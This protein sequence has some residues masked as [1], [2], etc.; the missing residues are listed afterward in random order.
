MATSTATRTRRRSGTGRRGPTRSPELDATRALALVAAAVVLVGAGPLPAWLAPR[1][2]ALTIGGALP[3]VFAV[4]AGV[5]IAHQQAA[6]AAAGFRWWTGRILRRVV[7][8]VAA[9]V[10]L[11]LLLALPTPALA[12]LSVTGDLA[13]LGVATGLGLVLVHVPARARDLLAAALLAAHGWL[14]VGA[15]A[16]TSAGGA[17]AGWDARLLA[18][19]A[20]SPVDPDG[21]TAVAPT[22]A[23]VL[24]GIA[25]GEW[26]RARPRGAPTV[27][28][29]AA[30][31]V[32]TGAAAAGLARVLPVL[33]AV[34]TAPV[35]AAGVALALA[36]LALGQLGTR[37]PWSDRWVATLAVAGRTTLPLW[38]LA[39]LAVRWF[40]GTPPVRWLLR[41]VLWPPLGDTGAVVALGLLL[42]T[43]LVRTGAALTDRG[44]DLRA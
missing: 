6:H 18:G 30:A 13:R 12:G 2:G 43:A 38:V 31:A 10:G 1:D 21:L 41:E 26:I 4:V 16:P 19:R 34:W 33:P 11:E 32:A 24:V 15:A 40:G 23:L 36:A 3:A 9:G 14:V 44:R 5:A 8:L 27:L 20:A 25:I 29:L 39:V 22:L 17:L 7:V 28:R 42:G 37:R 35:L